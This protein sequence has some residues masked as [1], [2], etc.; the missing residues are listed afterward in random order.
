M[1]YIFYNRELEV[2]LNYITDTIIFNKLISLLYKT[3]LIFEI[4]YEEVMTFHKKEISS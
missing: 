4:I 1:F 3:K 2:I